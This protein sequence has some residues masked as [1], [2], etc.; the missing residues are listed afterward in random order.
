MLAPVLAS[1]WK[2][3]R[4]W[5]PELKLLVPAAMQQRYQWKGNLNRDVLEVS[6]TYGQF[7]RFDTPCAPNT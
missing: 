3:S 5:V 6:S 4:A 2:T 7:R 1:L